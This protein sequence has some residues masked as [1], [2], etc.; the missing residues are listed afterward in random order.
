[1][2]RKITDNFARII[3]LAKIH[4]DAVQYVIDTTPKRAIIKLNALYKNDKILVTELYSDNIFKYRYYVLNNNFV[5]AGFDNASDPRAIRLKYGK[6]GKE[7]SGE[8]IPHLH[9]EDKQE[10]ILTEEMNF[11]KFL[12]W[13]IDIND[14]N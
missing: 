14:Q 11:D 2:D 4:F 3:E 1:L 6:I 8:L 13:L 12:A 5:K 7:H 9:L 10:L